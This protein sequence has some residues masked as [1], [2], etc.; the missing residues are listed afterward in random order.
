[1]AEPP[2]R[3][4]RT[5]LLLDL[6]LSRTGLVILLTAL[7]AMAMILRATK[8][9]GNESTFWLSLGS[10]ILATAV[11]STLSVILTTRQFDGFLRDSIGETIDARVASATESL[12]TTLERHNRRYL[13]TQEWEASKFPSPSYNEQLNHSISMT[14]TYIFQGVTGRLCVARLASIAGGIG[15]ARLIV[16][17]PTKSDSVVSR[18]KRDIDLDDNGESLAT[19]RS[20]LIDDIWLSII[21]AYLARGKIS[22]I[23]FC[24]IADPAIDRVEI[25]DSD[26]YISRFSDTVARDFAFPPA[27]RFGRDSILY[28]MHK[29]DCDRLFASNYTARF[30]IAHSD[31][32]HDLFKAL[33]QAGLNFEEGQYERLRLEFLNLVKGLTPEFL[34]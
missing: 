24:L 17:D 21:G 29:N 23:E 32:P 12:L 3:A 30:E 31:D 34:A 15:R 14:Q 2:T 9:S 16:A 33:N 8:T 7:A 19:V 5:R 18:A 20:Q 22:H 28:Q 1:M 13:P 4:S 26:V 10:G 27:A 11:Y 25:L 6:Y